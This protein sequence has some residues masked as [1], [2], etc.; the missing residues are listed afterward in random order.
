M[1]LLCCFGCAYCRGVVQ[2]FNAVHR[3]QSLLQGKLA[4]VGPSERRR[5]KAVQSFTKGRFFDMLK[6]VKVCSLDFC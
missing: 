3:Q 6:N 5:E 4:E 1:M 2:L